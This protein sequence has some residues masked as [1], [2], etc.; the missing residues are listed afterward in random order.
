M[1]SVLQTAVAQNAQYKAL[2]IYNFTKLIEW[3]SDT[4]DLDFKIG[5]YH[6]DEVLEQ[7]RQITKGKTVNG[8]SIIVEEIEKDSDE[9]IYE[10]IYFS[11]RHTE[12][13]LKSMK[14]LQDESVLIITDKRK[15]KHGINFIET[16]TSLN[17]EI[18]VDEIRAKGLKVS[19]TLLNLGIVR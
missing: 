5:V 13:V 3:P 2:Y 4:N 18:Y 14:S 15:A 11:G 6:N 17:F 12:W 7:L 19:N 1:L 8:R 9:S 16:E 10:L